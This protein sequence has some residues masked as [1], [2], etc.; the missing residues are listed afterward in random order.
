MVREAKKEDL[1]KLLKLYLFLHEDSVPE[2]DTHLE[3]TWDQIIE[4][5]NHHLIVNEIDGQMSLFD[6]ATEEQKEDLKITLPKV[7]DFDKDFL[8]MSLIYKSF[9][10]FNP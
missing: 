8:F 2:Y 6:F 5:P 9:K 4:D 10:S 7:E 1:D 3:K